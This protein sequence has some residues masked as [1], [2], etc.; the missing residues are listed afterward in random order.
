L[1]NKE[2][3]R[4]KENAQVF[5]SDKSPKSSKVSIDEIAQLRKIF[6]D[7]SLAK[8]IIFAGLGGIGALVGGAIELIHG[9]VDII[10]VIK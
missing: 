9:L 4:G 10:R 2:S 1:P 7:S 6:E 5:P 3:D 8:W